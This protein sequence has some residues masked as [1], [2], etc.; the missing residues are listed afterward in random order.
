MTLIH[1]IGEQMRSLDPATRRVALWLVCLVLTLAVCYSLLSRQ[2]TSLE[3]TKTARTATLQELRDLQQRFNEAT[4][5]SGRLTNRLATVRPEDTPVAILEQAGI[6]GTG[7][8][9]IKPLPRQESNGVIQEG[10]EIRLQGLSL[11]ELVNL[12]YQLENQ[13]KPVVVN[14]TVV[15]SR[16]SEPARL[17]L[18]L[19]LSL[20]RPGAPERK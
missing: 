4:A 14:K 9:Q 15:R 16:F 10:A 17:D 19:T 12:L 7:S 2:V 13:A 1:R 11:N 20:L 3:R 6:T 18:V 8:M 5:T